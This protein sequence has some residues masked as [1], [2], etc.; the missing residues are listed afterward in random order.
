MRAK[1]IAS[2]AKVIATN[3]GM[4]FLAGGIGDGA[5]WR[6]IEISFTVSSI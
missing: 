4:V 6:T 2:T 5:S 1:P 3:T